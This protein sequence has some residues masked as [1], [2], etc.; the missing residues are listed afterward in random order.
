MNKTLLIIIV[1]LLVVGGGWV[2]LQGSTTTAPTPTTTVT[3]TPAV[4][5]MEKKETEASPGEAITSKEVA[6]TIQNF[7]FSPK[8]VTVKKG[9]KVTWTNQDVASHT[10]TS[11]TGSELN[12][13][14]LGKGESFSHVFETSGTFAYHCTPHPNMQATVVVE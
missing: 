6:V 14:L 8:T 13:E 4:E 11:D 7:A 3:E 5:V 10:V 12:S 2:L 9:T 1:V